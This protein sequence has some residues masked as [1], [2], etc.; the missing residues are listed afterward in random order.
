[1]YKNKEDY[2]AYQ[3]KWRSEHPNYFKKYYQSLKRGEKRP[4]IFSRIRAITP[5]FFRNL[6]KGGK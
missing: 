5:A 2:Q 4:T 6:I 3:K 1:M